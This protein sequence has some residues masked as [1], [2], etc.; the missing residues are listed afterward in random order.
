MVA[1]HRQPAA[2]LLQGLEKAQA[3]G[4]AGAPVD[5]VSIHDD[6]VRIPVQD[7]LH[8]HLHGRE[9]A[10]HIRED[11][12]LHACGRAAGLLP[13]C[14]RGTSVSDRMDMGFTSGGG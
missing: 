1:E 14:G 10:L 2:P 4:A 9:V 13:G 5:Q 11:R 7:V 12:D 3:V 8:R 6:Q